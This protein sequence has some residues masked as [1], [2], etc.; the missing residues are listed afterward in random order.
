M[1]KII[2]SIYFILFLTISCSKNDDISEV[3]PS[4]ENTENTSPASPLQTPTPSENL[5]EVANFIK[6]SHKISVKTINGN[7]YSGYND[8][9]ITISDVNTGKLLSPSSLTFLP[10]MRMYS[11]INSKMVGHSHSCPHTRNL[12]KINNNHYRGYVIFQMNTGNTGHWDF[13]FDYTID[14]QDFKLSEQRIEIQKQPQN[15][16][17]KFTRFKAKDGKMYILALVSPAEHKNGR[18][19]NV[20]AGLF[21]AKSMT[22]FPHAQGFKLLLDPRM[23]GAD[24]QNHSTPFEGFSQQNNE[25][26]TAVINYSMTGHWILNFR[27]QNTE[28][29]IIA[30]TEVPKLPKTKED[31]EAVSEVHLPIEIANK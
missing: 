19:D 23:P 6:D 8:I 4:E 5:K 1:K 11:D 15:S 29:E 13:S 12:L 20:T 14:N 2:F 22:E 27:I 17:L 18:N 9:Y 26:H 21:V 16:H 25:F 7:L 28:N 24:M 10:M 30:G 31:F 3:N